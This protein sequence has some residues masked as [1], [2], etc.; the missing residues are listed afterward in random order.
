VRNGGPLT[1]AK[2]RSILMLTGTPQVAG[3]GVP[4]SQRIGP[5]PNLAK[6]QRLV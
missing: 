3:P 2:V 6:A 5:L 4:L 1:P